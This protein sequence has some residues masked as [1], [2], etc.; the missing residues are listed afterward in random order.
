MGEHVNIQLCILWEDELRAAAKALRAFAQASE[1]TTQAESNQLFRTAVNAC[2]VALWGLTDE[3]A[4]VMIGAGELNK[5][6][7]RSSE[8]Q[9]SE[10]KSG[11]QRTR[12]PL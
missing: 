10:Q 9:T 1:E 6:A 3:H 7:K 11:A 4:C 12:S 8:P 5:R 2:L